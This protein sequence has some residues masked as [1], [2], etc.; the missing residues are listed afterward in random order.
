MIKSWLVF[1]KLCF[2]SFCYLEIGYF[3]NREKNVFDFFCYEYFLIVRYVKVKESVD[4]SKVLKMLIFKI[5][6]R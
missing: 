6:F 2:K 5:F 3:V 1:N 4:V